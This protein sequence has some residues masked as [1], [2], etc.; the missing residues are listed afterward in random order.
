MG[1]RE[2]TLKKVAT[3]AAIASYDKFAA[4]GGASYIKGAEGR[5][6]YAVINSLAN[7][8]YGILDNEFPAEDWN[9]KTSIALTRATE[10]AG[11]LTLARRMLDGETTLGE[12]AEF[13][14]FSPL[15][16]PADGKKD[17]YKMDRSEIAAQMS[18]LGYDP[19]NPAE[20]KKFYERLSR[21][22][23][24]YLKGKAVREYNESGAGKATGLFLP[25][26]HGE[27][28]RQ[29]Y[30]DEPVDEGKLWRAYF[31]DAGTA[32]AMGG[33]ARIPSW[34]GSVA[35]TGGAEAAR[36][37]I[38]A[39]GFD[40]NPDL[41]A[42]P[43]AMLSMGLLPFSMRT[44]TNG[45]GRKAADKGART[46]FT[47]L[48]RGALG[49]SSPWEDE[50]NLIINNFMN[51][52]KKGAPTYKNPNRP[53][54]EETG[55][56]KKWDEQRDLLE[57]LGFGDVSRLGSSDIGPEINYNPVKRWAKQ[58]ELRNTNS[59]GVRAFTVDQMLG[60]PGEKGV[61]PVSHWPNKEL[62][63]P[64]KGK[65]ADNIVRKYLDDVL[66]EKTNYDT[67]QPKTLDDFRFEK[68][69]SKLSKED[70]TN[71]RRE[72][73]AAG[74]DEAKI[75][76]IHKKYTGVDKSVGAEITRLEEKLENKKGLSA[77][78]ILET[79][80]K[81]KK[82][83]KASEGT[84]IKTDKTEFEKAVKNA[85]DRKQKLQKYFPETIKALESG[86]DISKPRLRDRVAR[87]LGASL[88]PAIGTY[89]AATHSPIVT[90]IQQLLEGGWR[91]YAK[92]RQ[93]LYKKADWY[94]KLLKKNPQMAKALDAAMK[95]KE[96]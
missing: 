38:A 79:R 10:G 52:R 33:A 7:R 59:P 71:A 54:W 83:R 95:R 94:K 25:T 30:S 86:A 61:I 51:V 76:E 74:D 23:S 40:Q 3:D 53:T 2:N 46:F 12:K 64:A 81:L 96:D 13:A 17:W 22:N 42:V 80:E 77:L 21:H 48:R 62:L 75:A 18:D 6:N 92:D 4:G 28:I 31:T 26:M 91:D 44:I 36:Q 56:Q 60:A 5:N 20:V 32:A 68:A 1:E 73:L 55:V 88:G 82:L 34:V 15:F 66:S 70:A 9:P 35:A 89:E 50:K 84:E 87:G 27:A 69:L 43:E 90:G 65:E 45:M 39:K 57:A 11:A 14:A 29:A 41:S 72:L 37:A 24:N 67:F 78:E 49:Y 47:E 8:F 19:N 93:E 63:V 16:E 58:E 85:E